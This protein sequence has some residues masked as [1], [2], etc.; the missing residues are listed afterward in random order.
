[1]KPRQMAFDLGT[2][3][4][5]SAAGFFP[6]PANAA[7]FAAVMHWQGWPQGRMLLI[8]PAGAGKTHLAHIWAEAVGA[9][10]VPAAA[11]PGLDPTTL[12]PHLVIED[13]D[14]VAGQ[15]E[16]EEALFHSHNRVVNAGGL[17]LVTAPTP[18][19]DWGLHLPDLISRMQ[20]LPLARLEPPDDA[21]LSAVLVK[22]F[23]DRQITV[24]PNLI[25]YLVARM[26]R[27]IAAARQLVAG[28]DARALAAGRPIT[29]ALAAEWLDSADHG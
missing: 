3:E 13:A 15:P 16:A 22:L 24:P 17:L 14:Q 2:Q 11:L 19:R 6:A 20:A 4:T 25:P 10:I 21:L 7:A 23:S 12:P 8:G 9:E 26:E 29:R 27:S 5:Y 18:P 1:M 28:L